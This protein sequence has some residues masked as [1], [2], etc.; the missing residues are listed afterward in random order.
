MYVIE[1]NLIPIYKLNRK[2][3]GINYFLRIRLFDFIKGIFQNN[4]ILPNYT[5]QLRFQ[6]RLHYKKIS[7]KNP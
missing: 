6:D 5:T 1:T 7:L 3:N 2:Q 4:E